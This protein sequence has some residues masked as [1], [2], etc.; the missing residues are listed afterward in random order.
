[1]ILLKT[2]GTLV[3]ITII[4]QKTP[5]ARGGIHDEKFNFRAFNRLTN[6]FVQ[7]LYCTNPPAPIRIDQHI[8][9]PLL[10][11]RGHAKRSL[12]RQLFSQI[13]R[14]NPRGSDN[15]TALGLL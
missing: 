9:L 6:I 1:M 4:F 10:M 3:A 15:V 13:T 5:R 14:K 2:K 11:Q 12:P 8:I 7:N